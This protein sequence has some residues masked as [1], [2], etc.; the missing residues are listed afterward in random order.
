M[1]TIISGTVIGFVIL[2]VVYVETLMH[3][4]PFTKEEI[5]EHQK[6]LDEMDA[7]AK[8]NYGLEWKHDALTELEEGRKQMKCL[9]LILSGVFLIFVLIS[10]S[11]ATTLSLS[12][13]GIICMSV[14]T[15]ICYGLVRASESKKLAIGILSFV[16]VF[17]A[18]IKFVFDSM[19]QTSPY[20]YFYLG[21][22][23]L[24]VAVLSLILKPKN[25]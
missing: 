4:K 9:A 14:L 11:L 12:N 18:F 23:I 15:L 21:G 19:L 13:I 8:V 16:F 6:R 2:V 22:F 24:T 25:A 7:S 1:E 10:L 3:R 5:S 17:G 20:I